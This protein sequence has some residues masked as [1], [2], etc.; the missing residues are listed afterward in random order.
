MFKFLAALGKAVLIFHQEEQE[1]QL[2]NGALGREGRGRCPVSSSKQRTG[3]GGRAGLQ[4]EAARLGPWLQLLLVTDVLGGRFL[5]DLLHGILQSDY[6]ENSL[7]GFEGGGHIEVL[8]GGCESRCL[9][10]S[11]YL[12]RVPLPPTTGMAP[13]LLEKMLG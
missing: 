9:L 12:K 8:T 2:A 3:E 5:G 4:H 6:F 13:S 7:L 10:W 1:E 11:R